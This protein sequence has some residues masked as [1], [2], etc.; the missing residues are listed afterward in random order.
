MSHLLLLYEPVNLVNHAL[1]SFICCIQCYLHAEGRSLPELGI[2]VYTR[3]GLPRRQ[4]LQQVKA[5]DSHFVH[6][7]ELQDI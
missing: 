6:K 5:D 4:T 2:R 3:N 7:G 1:P